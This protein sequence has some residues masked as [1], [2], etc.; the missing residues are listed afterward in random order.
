MKETKRKIVCPKC[1]GKGYLE[2]EAGL[3]RLTCSY[4]GGTGYIKV[5]EV[6]KSNKGKKKKGK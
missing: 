4:C 3:I 1:N 6:E 5:E 2:Y